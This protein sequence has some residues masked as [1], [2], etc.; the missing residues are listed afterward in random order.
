MTIAL[1][2]NIG[3]VVVAIAIA[4]VLTVP[5]IPVLTLSIVLAAT[6]IIVPIVTW[7][8]SHTLWSAIDLRF[9]P[10]DEAEAAEAAIWL[11]DRSALA[12]NA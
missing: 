5:D 2:L 1:I 6:S 4:I 10:V 9:R 12:E 11:A 8:I 3:L 7:P